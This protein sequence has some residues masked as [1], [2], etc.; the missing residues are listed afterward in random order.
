MPHVQIHPDPATGRVIVA[1][2]GEIDIACAAPFREALEQ[3]C[4]GD[5]DAVT[6]DFG[7]VTFAD[8]TAISVLIAAYKALNAQSRSLSVANVGP[9]QLR[10]FRTVGLEDMLGVHAAADIAAAS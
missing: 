2:E 1:P 6:V 10:M 3:A 4:A 8:S 7:A 9:V 5:S